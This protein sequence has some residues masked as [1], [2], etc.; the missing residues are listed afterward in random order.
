M[1]ARLINR[2]LGRDDREAGPRDDREA[3]PQIRLVINATDIDP[4]TVAAQVRWALRGN[5]PAAPVRY[6]ACAY[7]DAGLG[8]FSRPVCPHRT[9]QGSPSV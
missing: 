2:L 8:F 5:R 3:G 7:E 4:E 1:L 6:A 9:P